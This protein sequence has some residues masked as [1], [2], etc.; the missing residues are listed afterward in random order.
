MSDSRKVRLQTRVS[1]ELR[2]E[3][4][5]TLQLEGRSVSEDLRRHVR[6]VVRSGAETSGLP[7][8]AELREAYV[9]LDELASPDDRRVRASVAMSQLAQSTQRPKK[10]VKWSVLEPL[11][12]RGFI[13]VWNAWITVLETGE[14]SDAA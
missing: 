1:E 3:Y 14:V 4:E 2:E 12:D 10:N 11:Q 5:R 6:D 13:D 8:E 7:D 9:L